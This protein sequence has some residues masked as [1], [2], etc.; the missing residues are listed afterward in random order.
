MNNHA[1][2]PP[3]FYPIFSLTTDLTELVFRMHVNF[4]MLL[5][6]IHVSLS[7]YVAWHIL[8]LHMYKSVLKRCF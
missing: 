7:N 6:Y 3:E 2:I 1:P 4:I 8:E 5:L